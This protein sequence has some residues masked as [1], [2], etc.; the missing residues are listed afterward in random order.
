M[1]LSTQAIFYSILS[2]SSF[3]QRFRS[4]EIH[5]LD[6]KLFLET[7]GKIARTAEAYHIAD[8][9]DAIV[10]F[11]QKLCAL[12]QFHELYH[13]VWRNIG[14]TANLIEER[15]AAHAHFL[16]KER[17]VEF[18]ICHILFDNIRH[19]LQKRIINLSWSYL[20]YRLKRSMRELTP[21][22]T[23]HLEKLSYARLK[24][25]HRERLFYV[26]IGSTVHTLRL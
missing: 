20:C 7:L 1:H 21:Q 17:H 16:G 19:L 6:A 18:R 14:K 2:E 11:F 15:R 4:H 23:A 3:I 13:L 24:I 26:D 12:L 25:L 22:Q 5:R 8:F 10:S 9:A